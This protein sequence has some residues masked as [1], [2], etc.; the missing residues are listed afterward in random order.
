MKYSNPADDKA[1]RIGKII[2]DCLAAL[3]YLSVVVL[4]IYQFMR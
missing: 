2:G 3:V 1:E 4:L